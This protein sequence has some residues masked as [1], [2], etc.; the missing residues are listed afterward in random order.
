ML[1]IGDENAV[2]RRFERRF[3]QCDGLF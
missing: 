3:Q 2:M 1:Q